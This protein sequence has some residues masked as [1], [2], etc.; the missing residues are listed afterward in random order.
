MYARYPCYFTIDQNYMLSAIC[1][2]D[3][4]KVIARYAEKKNGPYVCPACGCEVTLKKGDVK[5][6]HFVHKA[7]VVCFMGVVETEFLMNAK[8]SIFDSLQTESNVFDLEMEKPLGDSIAD[9]FAVIEGVPVAIMIQRSNL[10]ISDINFTTQNYHHLGIAVL[11]VG[12]PV[13]VLI[14]DKYSPKDVEKWCQ[15]ACYG[16]LYFW[17]GGQML[18]PVHFVPYMEIA[19]KGEKPASKQWKTPMQGLP[20]AISRDFHLVNKEP[21]SGS[22]VSIPRCTLFLDK[23]LKWW[24]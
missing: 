23:Q 6:H 22:G 3:D 1:Q 2:S 13:D 18:M 5:M 9:V 15:T 11:W 16:R 20:A 8:M 21:W 12:L 10:T 19:P 4:W 24:R 17:V 7:P 14:A